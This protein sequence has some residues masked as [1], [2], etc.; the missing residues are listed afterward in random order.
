MYLDILNAYIHNKTFNHSMCDT[1]KK[2]RRDRGSIFKVETSGK[3]DIS[4]TMKS[5]WHQVSFT[6]E[7]TI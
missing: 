4:K 5:Q 3:S 6:I 1:L 7:I 2:K